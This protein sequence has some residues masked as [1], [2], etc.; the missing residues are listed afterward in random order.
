MKSRLQR[1]HESHTTPEENK[2]LTG[3]ADINVG[4]SIGQDKVQKCNVWR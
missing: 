1:E 2:N 4:I 3:M